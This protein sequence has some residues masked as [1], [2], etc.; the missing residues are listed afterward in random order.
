M[1]D[2]QTR[3]PP[4]GHL[5]LIVHNGGG[6]G[7]RYHPG[8]YVALTA[9]IPDG[10]EFVKWLNVDGDGTFAAAR[11]ANGTF[12]MGNS[13]SEIAATS[14]KLETWFPPGPEGVTE[15]PLFPVPGAGQSGRLEQRLRITL[16]RGTSARTPYEQILGDLAV[17]IDWQPAA[18]V[19]FFTARTG[20]REITNAAVLPGSSFHF[21]TPDTLETSIWYEGNPALRQIAQTSP[22]VVAPDAS[23]RLNLMVD[24]NRKRDIRASLH[25]SPL[26]ISPVNPVDSDSDGVPDELDA[27]PY[28]PEVDWKRVN[29][30][31][32]ALIEIDVPEEAG[33]VRDLNDAGHVLFDG[34]VW[35]AGHWTKLEHVEIE[36]AFHLD[37]H[38]F[39]YHSTSNHG[40]KLS[41]AGDVLEFGRFNVYGPGD[42]ED[43]NHVLRREYR[44]LNS[45]YQSPVGTLHTIDWHGLQGNTFI[46][47]QVLGEDTQRRV[48]AFKEFHAALPENAAPEIWVL[49]ANLDKSESGQRQ[50]PAGHRLFMHG[51]QVTPAGWLAVNSYPYTASSIPA[52]TLVWNP[53]GQEIT[54]PGGLPWYFSGFTELPHGRPALACSYHESNGSVYLLKQGWEAFKA[55]NKLSGK[56]IHTFAGDGTAM[57]SDGHMWINGE[58]IPIRDLCPAY[59]QMLQEGWITHPLKANKH[60]AY[61]IAAEGPGALQETKLLLPV[62]LV[63]DLNNDGQITAADNPLR[64]AAMAGGATDEIKDKGTEFI[65]HNDTLSNG[66]W[67]KEDTDP[68]KPAT[69]KDDDDAEEIRVKVGI[70]EGEVW[71]EHPAIAKLS[72]YKTRECKPADK[73][74][75]SPTSKFTVS[76]SNPFPDKLFMQADVDGALTYPPANPQFEGDLVLKIK[77]G[78]NG[79]EIEA[80][81]MKLTVAKQL[82]AK[83]FF[84][85]AR[86]YILE[87]NTELFVQNWG[88][89]VA[90][91]TVFMRMCVMREE[92][93]K[94]SPYESYWDDAYKGYLDSNPPPGTPFE[95]SIY[96]TNG[97]GIDG[98][99]SADNAMTVVINGN[100]CDFTDPGLPDPRTTIGRYQRLADLTAMSLLGEPE[101]TDR[102]HGRVIID[103]KKNQSSSDFDDESALITGTSFRGSDLAG[104][105]PVTGTTNPG[106]KYIAQFENGHFEMG[107]G[108]VPWPS[109]AGTL[110]ITDL[111]SN[112]MGGLSSNYGSSARNNYPNSFVGFAPMHEEGK[113]AVFVAS[114]K[115]TN[116]KGKVKEFYEA[117]KSSDVPKIPGASVSGALDVINLAMLDSG[118][119]SCALSHKNP[120]GNHE[121]YYKGD[122]HHGMPYYTNTFLRFKAQKPR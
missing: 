112:A 70:T 13:H 41:P 96:T 14:A 1:L 100:Q 53:A 27:D 44:P 92:A 71:L 16:H 47:L 74:N 75:L 111:A 22:A 105:D 49:D 103:G 64:D 118:N 87:N 99:V 86:D 15:G 51:N 81:K 43:I 32:Y 9:E 73:V 28:D 17:G 76:A 119:T 84:H 2:A 35:N 117:A 30:G 94:M 72:F 104:E 40:W 62:D 93:T 98:A 12:V 46:S 91:P 24:G 82:G 113:G 108:R 20:G 122:K 36:G 60:G 50:L 45:S 8:Q 5:R 83:K 107:A 56:R 85:A 26:V 39:S 57:T 33:L 80:V 63:S 78:T 67:D 66:I 58:L 88:Y 89:P 52:R 4:T 101:V 79:Q 90:N 19:R 102:C 6:D 55:A 109:V 7:V 106:G 3:P 25:A 120:D 110:P 31:G 38:D 23:I 34:G 10:F 59:G 18:D 116:G 77:V 54:A 121:M 11:H 97:F 115:E 95:P 21:T 114:G 69:E 65:F 29:V 68:A 48:F 42:V 37:P 61:L